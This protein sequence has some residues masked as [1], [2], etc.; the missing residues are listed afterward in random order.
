M[1]T[2]V[3]VIVSNLETVFF[4]NLGTGSVHYLS[5]PG[6]CLLLFQVLIYYLEAGDTSP[7]VRSEV[8]PP[9]FGMATEDN[10]DS[11]VAMRSSTKII[12]CYENI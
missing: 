8:Q 1:L 9:A 4:T 12:I 6:G 10:L 2:P 3:T 7:D 5:R 11:E